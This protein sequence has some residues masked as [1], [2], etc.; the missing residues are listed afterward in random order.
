MKNLIPFC[1]AAITCLLTAFALMYLAL[2]SGYPLYGGDTH[3]YVTIGFNNVIPF[4]RSPFYGWFLRHTSLH[5][6]LWF[7]ILAQSLLLAYVLLRFF[8]LL[9]GTF[10]PKVLAAFVIGTVA[11]TFV[12]RSASCLMSDVF[13]P[14]L[15]LAL[16][17]YYLEPDTPAG[18]KFVYRALIFLSI[19]MHNSHFL[20]VALLSALLLLYALVKKVRSIAVRAVATLGLSVLY[21]ITMSGINAAAGNGFVFSRSSSLF[22]VTK[23]AETG[24]LNQYL[25]DNCE[26][27]HLRLCNN[28]QNITPYPWEFMYYPHSPYVM[29]GGYDSCKEELSFIAHDVL[30]TPK[31]LKQYVIKAAT[32]TLRQLTEVQEIGDVL[33][34]PADAWQRQFVKNYFPQEEKEFQRSRQNTGLLSMYAPNAVNAIFFVLS[35]IA[36][37]LLYAKTG[38]KLVANVYALI[39]AFFVINAMVTA[40]GSTV[41]CRYMYRIFWILPATNLAIIIKYLAGMAGA[42][43][44]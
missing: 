14:V 15:L 10:D 11:F 44:K 6:S 8:R 33:C 37:L 19:T 30:T 23:F 18:R 22:M 17:L 42:G 39:L 1:Q 36:V 12:S 27:K 13:T 29:A 3:A 32:A 21:F 43:H 24:I 2:Y 41:E 25:D 4:D 28:R 7:P 16:L 5:E 35:T 40:V 20:I 31:Y 26:T 9:A 34:L 38:N